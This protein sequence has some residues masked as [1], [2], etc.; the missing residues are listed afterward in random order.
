MSPSSSPSLLGVSILI[1]TFKLG[2]TC[3]AVLNVDKWGR[4]PLLLGGVSGMVIALG[5][6][7]ADGA[8]DLPR[9]VGIVSLL[10]FVGSYQLSYGPISWLIIGELFPLQVRRLLTRM[11]ISR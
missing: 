6:L 7:G 9:G 2:M 10:L 1:G 4:R 8:M 5:L 11:K 3:I